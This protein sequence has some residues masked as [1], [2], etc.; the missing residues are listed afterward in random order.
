MHPAHYGFST[1]T[2][3]TNPLTHSLTLWTAAGVQAGQVVAYSQPADRHHRADNGRS[4]QPLRR[5]RHHRLHLRRHGHAALRRQLH[6]A[7][8]PGRASLVR[9]WGWVTA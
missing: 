5:P 4:R 7:V 6:G 2:R 9:V 3:Y 8:L 1:I